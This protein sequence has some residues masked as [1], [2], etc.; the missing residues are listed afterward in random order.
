MS[1]RFH[2][3]TGG[4][5]VLVVAAATITPITGRAATALYVA[6]VEQLYAAVN[7][8]ANAGASVIL[9]PNIYVLS[10]TSPAGS[11]RP[12]GGRLDLQQDM[13]L[14][15]VSGDRAA[16]IIDATAPGLSFTEGMPP[17]QRTGVIRTGRG[18]NTVEWLTIAGNPLAAAAIDTDLFLTLEAH[19]RVAH[20]VA[21]N[22]SRGV[23][24]RNLGAAMSGRRLHADI[25]DGEFFGSI[26][27]IRVAN[28]QGADRGEINVVMSGNRSHDN[29]LGCIVANNRSSFAT[30]H[31][32]SNGDRFEGNGLGCQIVGGLVGGSGF[33]NSN[34]TVFEAHGTAFSNNNKRSDFCAPCGGPT[35]TDF[36]GL[37][38]VGGD[39]IAAAFANTTSSNTVTVRLFGS[40][41]DENQTPPGIDF[42]AFGAHFAD[43]SAL[44]GTDNHVTIELHGV[45]AQVDPVVVGSFPDN[46]PGSDTNTVT[47]FRSPSKP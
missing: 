29:T 47:I 34:S 15:G 12:N 10:S 13:S 43:L 24:V 32:R 45:S 2:R 8:P 28:F 26:E 31:V 40:K 5:A 19:V 23:D 16:V 35:F 46:L 25:V 36:G 27:S 9:A 3:L 22:S 17:G 1:H 30:I 41:V 11:A 44:A 21:G 20:V 7:N 6:D 38:V 33:A 39:V 14:Y 37:L 4:A 18:S 42:Q